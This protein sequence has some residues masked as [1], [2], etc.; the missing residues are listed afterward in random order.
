MS[1][2]RFARLADLGGPRFV[3]DFDAMVLDGGLL[4]ASE[5]QRYREL[6]RKI[7]ARA[8]DRV[9]EGR[10]QDRAK[11]PEGFRYENLNADEGRYRIRVPYHWGDLAFF[12]FSA[13]A[14]RVSR[15][16]E[17]RILPALPGLGMPR[18]DLEA[19]L[20]VFGA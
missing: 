20:K 14:A 8:Q 5:V 12:A 2:T 11:F 3:A 17:A 7:A 16:V 9:L 10:A 13:I 6:R 19:Y 1:A 15:I 4:K 18:E